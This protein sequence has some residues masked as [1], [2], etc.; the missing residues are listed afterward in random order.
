MGCGNSLLA[1]ALVRA[2]HRNVTA[3]DFSVVAVRAMSRRCGEQRLEGRLQY[4]A[5]D[6]RRLPFRDGSFDWVVDKGCLDALLNAHDQFLHWQA[7]GSRGTCKARAPFTFPP[8]SRSSLALSQ[9]FHALSVQYDWNRAMREGREMLN[10]VRRVL[11][12]G[13]GAFVAISYEDPR[14]RLM[15]LRTPELN[16]EVQYEEDSNGNYVYVCTPRL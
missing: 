9:T 7:C 11:K 13:N 1:E 15:F 14:G 10:E 3:V 5:A 2:G 8:S 6:V 4:A 16:W 12:G